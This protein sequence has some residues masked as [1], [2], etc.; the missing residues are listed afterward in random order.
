M[1]SLDLF[2]EEERRREK[3]RDPLLSEVEDAFDEKMDATPGPELDKLPGEQLFEDE[4]AAQEL[5]ELQMVVES[6]K[7][8]RETN[9]DQAAEIKRLSD[10]SG[11]PEEI[12]QENP[13]GVKES[14]Q[15]Q[16]LVETLKNSPKL[17]ESAVDF[18][19]SGMTI[20]KI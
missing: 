13:E 17:R 14:L 6:F 20:L 18:P 7:A 3:L 4:E 5:K 8:A 9:P 11:Y 16:Q 19:G 1:D 10:K 2:M 12:V 15:T